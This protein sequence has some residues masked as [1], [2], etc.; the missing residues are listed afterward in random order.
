MLLLLLEGIPISVAGLLW[1]LVGL[2]T[3]VNDINTSFIR[4]TNTIMFI[5]LKNKIHEANI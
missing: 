2:V 1:L 3:C 4:T 5:A